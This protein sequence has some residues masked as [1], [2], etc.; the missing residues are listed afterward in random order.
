MAR[1]IATW[2][3]AGAT[4]GLALTGC[5]PQDE[6]RE[7][8]AIER[9]AA[10][11]VCE[12]ERKVPA[13]DQ[14]VRLAMQLRREFGFRADRA[15][16]ERLQRDPAARARQAPEDGAAFPLTADEKPYF[17]DRYVV[18]DETGAVARYVGRIRG[19][20]GG[21]SIEDDGERGAYVGLRV[22]RDLTKTERRALAQRAR[23]LRLTRVRYSEAE[24]EHT[25][26]QVD[27]A[28]TQSS[29]VDF[30][31]SG[32]DTDRNAVVLEYTS[33]SPDAADALKRRFGDRLVAIRRPVSRPACVAPTSYRVAADG[34][35][36]TLHWRSEPGGLVGRPRAEVREV[37]DH[38]LVGGIENHTTG[39]VAPVY[40][41]P[42]SRTART[43]LS[44][45][46]GTRDLVAIRSGRKVP[47][48]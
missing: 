29:P 6:E 30:Q 33:R 14:D 26:R 19:L 43:T 41:P 23:R 12:R 47:R 10:G 40:R 25:H 45:P 2:I 22:T 11:P 35:R 36:I 27:D 48:R 4:A 15:Y 7:Q 32:V 46:L 9:P 42:V 39:A 13:F 38:V 3:L 5:G 20:S 21:V 37:G 1:R 24:L 34:R 17:K 31:E 16:V 28:T 18:Q 44:R 8:T